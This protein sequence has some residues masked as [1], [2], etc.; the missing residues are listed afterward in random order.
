MNK[1]N[2]IPNKNIRTGILIIILIILISS[3]KYLSKVAALFL[4]NNGDFGPHHKYHI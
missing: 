3:I 2:Q 4:P 1:N